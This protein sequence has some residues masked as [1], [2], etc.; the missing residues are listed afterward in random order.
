MLFLPRFTDMKYV[1]S[2]FTNGGHERVSSPLPGSSI[3]MT[4]AP[5]SPKIIEQKGPASTLVR[6]S[7]RTPDSGRSARGTMSHLQPRRWRVVS[8]TPGPRTRWRLRALVDV[9]RA[10]HA[11]GQTARDGV[12]PVAGPPR[13]PPEQPRAVHG[14]EVG[15][16]IDVIDRLDGDVGAHLQPLDI[17]AVA[18]EAR[19]ALELH[20]RD[21]QRRLEA[22]RRRV[23][24]R[25]RDDLAQARQ[26][27]R[28][29]QHGMMRTVRR[30][31]RHDH[32]TPRTPGGR[33]GL[34]HW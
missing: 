27:G 5:M 34:D 7:T 24:R 6:S 33:N 11:L 32:L 31:R 13:A 2:P 25:E 22:G 26:Y 3:L 16:V 29:H 10:P 19:A 28:R 20:D 21:G 23:Q 4:S 8:H 18:D 30:R 1:A 17:A 9:P 12:D 14:A 15:E